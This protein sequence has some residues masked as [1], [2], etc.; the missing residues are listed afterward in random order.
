MATEFECTSFDDL[1]F[2][3]GGIEFKYSDCEVLS[4]RE[5]KKY[6][7]VELMLKSPCGHYAE[8]LVTS[9]DKEPSKD[10]FVRGEYDGLVL[11]EDVVLSMAKLAKSY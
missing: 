1:V 10:N 6:P 4:E 5:H 11:D 8:L 7:H 3:I 2:I 9:H